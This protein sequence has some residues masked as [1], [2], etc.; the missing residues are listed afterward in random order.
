MTFRDMTRIINY[1][2]VAGISLCLKATEVKR[3]TL[4]VVIIRTN[5]VFL[6]VTSTYDRDF[7]LKAYNGFKTYLL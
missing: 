5:Q 4:Y 2:Q 6:Y 1:E 3:K 7:A